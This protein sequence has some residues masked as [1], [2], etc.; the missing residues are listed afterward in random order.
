M[1]CRNHKLTVSHTLF[2]IIK[3]ANLWKLF[4]QTNPSE[5]IIS[6]LMKSSFVSHN[7]NFSL[8][9]ASHSQEHEQWGFWI[10]DVFG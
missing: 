9:M 2:F 3:G 1:S 4:A 10:L 7:L 5:V 6:N 8:D